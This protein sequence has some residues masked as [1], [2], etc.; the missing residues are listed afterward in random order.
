MESSFNDLEALRIAIDIENRGYNFYHLAYEKF[1]EPKM[2]ALFKMLMEEEEEHLKTFSKYFEAVE[3]TKEAHSTD[4]LF[5]PEISGYLTVLAEAHVFPLP[6]DAPAILSKIENPVEVF[7]L[8]MRAEKDSIL[9][10]SELLE[11]SKIPK[12]REV[13]KRLKREEQ[14]HTVELGQKIQEIMHEQNN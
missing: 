3:Q 6:K 12:A 1:T 5:D 11:C 4:Y 7:I 14:R 13:F 2:K 9:F 8:A 10:Y